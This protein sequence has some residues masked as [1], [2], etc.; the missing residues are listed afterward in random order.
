MK[1]A[2]VIDWLDKYGGAERVIS[3]LNKEYHFDQIYTLINIMSEHDLKK[4]C[5][6]D[7]PVVNTTFLQKTGK[8]FRAFFPFFPFFIKKLKVDNDI[9]LIISSSHC[10]AKGINKSRDN[11]IHFC[12]FQARNFKYVWEEAPLYFGKFSTLLAPLLRFLQKIDVE[13]AKQPDYIIANS[14]FVQ[15]WIKEQYNRDSIVIYPPVDIHNFK[16]CE[17]K[18]DYYVTVGRL[19]E[20]KRFDVI[21]EAFNTNKKKLI[22]IGDGKMKSKLQKMAH[23][24]IEFKGFLESAEINNIIS[25]AKGFIHAGIEDFGIAPIE[26]QACG[27]P[28]LAFGK[29]GVLET[30]IDSETGVFFHEQNPE[31]LN[32]AIEIFE[33]LTFNKAAIRQ[34]ALR[35]SPE[36]FISQMNS[37]L[38]EK[39]V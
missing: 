35:F 2:I 20:Y 6:L 37:Y 3:V 38:N 12:Y 32:N 8:F 39:M 18:E 10:V 25:K 23:S 15:N 27:T 5:Q 14:K 33:S 7:S 9:D 36:N 13:Q 26:A 1:R 22:V 16:L 19:V 34:N 17:N 21:I 28:V 31:S 30:V 29:G 4:I 24:N 11:Q